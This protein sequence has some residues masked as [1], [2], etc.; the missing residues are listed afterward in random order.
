MCQLFKL[1]VKAEREKK[2]FVMVKIFMGLNCCDKAEFC[3]KNVFGCNLQNHLI[4]VVETEKA[5]ESHDEHV[6]VPRIG[7]PKHVGIT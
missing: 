6:V 1:T 5:V 4:V 2:G 3:V 7:H